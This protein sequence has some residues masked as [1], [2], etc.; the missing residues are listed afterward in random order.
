MISC[1][2]NPALK[3]RHREMIETILGFN[4]TPE[5]PMTLGRLETLKG[6]QHV[7]AIQQVSIKASQEANLEAI[8]KKVSFC[9][10]E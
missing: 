10:K 6:F 1:L 7:E 5:E 9:V 2:L 8:L 4:F 3:N